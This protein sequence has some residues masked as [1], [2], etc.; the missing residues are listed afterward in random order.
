MFVDR[1]GDN[2]YNSKLIDDF[3]EWVFGG[4]MGHKQE[5]QI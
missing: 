1:E 5:G 4:V 2:Q 3:K